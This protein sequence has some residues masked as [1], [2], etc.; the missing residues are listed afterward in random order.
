M[1]LPKKKVKPGR[2]VD[3]SGGQ[4]DAIDPDLL[5]DNE[6]VKLQCANLDQKGTLMPDKGADNRYTSDFDAANPVIGIGSFNKSD[7]TTRLIMAAGTKLFKDTPHLIKTFDVQADWAT[8]VTKCN[9][10]TDSVPGSVKIGAK[11]TNTFARASVA[12]NDDGTQVASGVPRY[13]TGKFGNGVWIEEG[14]TN[15]L[16]ANQSSVETDLTGLALIGTVAKMTLSR[17]TTDKW[18][19][20]SCIQVVV[21]DWVP[22]DDCNLATADPTEATDT[23]VLP[24]TT[25]TASFYFKGAVGTKMGIRILLW[26]TSGEVVTDSGVRNSTNGNGL[27]QRV[28]YTFTTTA[29]TAY[30][31]LRMYHQASGTYLYD[32]LQI[33]QKAYV[34]SW[35]IGGTARNADN[36]YYT[37]TN[38][39]PAKNFGC[40]WW[41]PDRV[42][43]AYTDV[44][45]TWVMNNTSVFRYLLQY[46]S[47]KFYFKKNDG[48]TVYSCESTA[49][50]F[51]AGDNIFIAWADDPVT[52]NMKLWVGINTG[53]IAEYT[54]ANTVQITDAQ[55]VY[56]GCRD[57]GGY[58]A[59]GVIDAVQLIDVPALE[60][61]GTTFNSTFVNNQY[62]AVSA[63]TA[64]PAHLLLANMESIAATGTL[65]FTGSVSDGEKVTIGSRV[66]EFDTNSSVTAGN[67]AV[68]VSGG[69]TAPAAVTA[70]VTAITGDAS[71]TVT[72]VDGAGDTVVVTAKTKGSAANTTATTETC[73]NA[74]WGSATLTGGVDGITAADIAGGVWISPW[75]DVSQAID[76]NSGTI[77]WE[78]NLP[79]GTSLATKTRTSVDQVTATAWAGA[80]NGGLIPSAFNKYLQVANVLSRT[81]YTQN[82]E[83]Q[84][85]TIAYDGTPTATEL[86]TGL[87]AG[88]NVFMDT[89]LDTVMIVN[90]IDT[91]KKW[92]GVSATA[93]DLGGN[94]P[95]G[96]YIAVHKNRVFMLVKSRLWISDVLNNESWP[97]LN[98]I[99]ISPNDGD[100][101]TG[102]KTASD[103]LVITKR[104]SV[105][106]LVGDSISNFAVRRLQSDVGCIAPRSL[107]MVND[108]LSFIG[109]DG[110]YFC[111]F[112]TV[113]LASE[114]IRGTWNG[115]NQRRLSQAASSY[116]DHVLRIA[117]PNGSSTQNNFLIEYD[118]IRQSWR[119]RNDWNIS[120]WTTF[121]EAGK[122]VLLFGH[123]QKGQVLEAEKN[124]SNNGVGIN[125]EWQS[126]HFH[127]GVP[128]RVKRFRKLYLQVK[129]ALTD[130]PINIYFTVDGG[131]F[132]TPITKIIPGRSDNKIETILIRPASVGVLR[133]HMIGFKITQNTPNAAV[134]IHSLE[135]E[136]FIKGARPTI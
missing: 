43:T 105:H 15:L 52:G 115:L 51:N 122:Q 112:A 56:V 95:R 80:S 92:D 108:L 13:K 61:S 2:L 99:D 97:V 73:A 120:C 84:K 29:S 28:S 1:P 111:D 116:H 18:T 135:L 125:F 131:P 58:E 104:R 17:I 114:R 37:L 107:C 130:V 88:G 127:F 94:P 12:Y 55:K 62:T 119:T 81:D 76:Q 72:A 44:T 39:L 67:V 41:K 36:L 14:S 24:N 65:T 109:N 78:N 4:N 9:V 93:S 102:L 7:E 121:T 32:G 103:Y 75:Q 22:G 33:E 83:L 90:G 21:T 100:R 48:T 106:L 129:P 16:T 96:E 101:G 118:T 68:N 54:L 47:G 134:G 26:N 60:A 57:V 6:S 27:W 86:L 74:S 66:Y 71:A 123:S 69:A 79:T 40:L 126:K 98:F 132:S 11:P 23:A 77:S 45:L 70:L 19:G 85:V 136:Y 124:F 113:T 46:Y 35:Q 49:L 10:D 34:T 128:E 3:F 63:P 31:N 5:N 91:P 117:V 82:P 42:S 53:A 64:G 133:G 38:A 87:T 59:N 50:T 25:Y 30:M 8:G 110:V 20:S 89:L